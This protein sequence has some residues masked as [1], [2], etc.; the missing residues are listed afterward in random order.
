MR[1][2][3]FGGGV[4]SVAVLVLAAQQRVQYDHFLFANVGDNA[5]N[6][7]T[8][9]Y[10]EQIS[11]PYAARHGIDLIELYHIVKGEKRDLYDYL[12]GDNKSV[13]IPV[14]LNN[15]YRAFFWTLIVG[16]VLVALLVAFAA[17]VAPLGELQRLDEQ[18]HSVVAGQ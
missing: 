9:L 12:M 14:R 13:K 17:T 6:P 16:A 11:K 3:S 4:Q 8:L 10:T 1:T 2:F 5:E 7:D 15:S 18:Q